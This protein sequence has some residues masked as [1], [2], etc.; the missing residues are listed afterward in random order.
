MNQGSI[1]GKEIINI[2]NGD[3]ILN[4]GNRLIKTKSNVNDT[5]IYNSITGDTAKVISIEFSNYIATYDFLKTIYLSSGDTIVISQNHGLIQ[6]PIGNGAYYHSEG[7]QGTGVGYTF[8][9]FEDVF[10]GYQVGDAFQLNYGSSGMGPPIYGE[11]AK[12]KFTITG[13]D[14]SNSGFNYRVDICGTTTH[15]FENGFE[16]TTNYQK[17]NYVYNPDSLYGKSYGYPGEITQLSMPLMSD[18]FPTEGSDFIFGEEFNVIGYEDLYSN[19]RYGYPADFNNMLDELNYESMN[20]LADSLKIIWKGITGYDD[21]REQSNLTT[22]SNILPG[23]QVGVADGFH[24]NNYS[25]SFMEGIGIINMGWWHFEIGHGISLT[26]LRKN[27]VNY[28]SMS[29][30]VIVGVSEI[31]KPLININIYPNPF[32]SELT[33]SYNDSK[34]YKLEVLDVTG[35]KIT[36][37]QINPGEN[38]ISLSEIQGTT[39]ILRFISD[40]EVYTKRIIRLNRYF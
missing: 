21:M 24:E 18:I 34:I 4:P 28:G 10:Y 14:S 35:R 13:I 36:E 1:P 2:G 16:N 6:F 11:F 5:W 19:I 12:R 31:S 30:C 3:F 22:F 40:N 26:G 8:P 37:L 33:I 29:D 20:N 32:E 15:I 7:V 23:N 25:M 27:G 39:F 9:S 17:V 38:N